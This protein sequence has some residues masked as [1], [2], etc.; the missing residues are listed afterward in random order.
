M[1]GAP[2]IKDVAQVAGVHFTTVS[3]ALRGHPSIRA[4][5][6]DR[7]VA[8]AAR[9]GYRKDQVFSALSTRRS[10][11]QVPLY[12]PKIAF[13]HNR[14]PENG[15]TRLPHFRRMEE[16]AR[17]QAEA[18]GYELETVFLDE[19]H[20]SSASLLDY[21]RA[22]EIRGIVLAVLEPGR[23]E[24]Q[25]PW[26]EFSVV[27]IETR[28]LAP[29]FL[30]VA[31]DQG[32]AVKTSLQRLQALGYQRIGL[33]IGRHDE[34]MTGDDNVSH[35]L[36]WSERCT[37]PGIPP[38]L[39]PENSSAKEVI[40]PLAA[41]V[42]EHRLDAVMCNWTNVRSMLATAGFTVPE[43]VAC[44]CLCLDRRTPGLAGVATALDLLAEHAVS[45]LATLLRTERRGPPSVATDTLVRGVW[46]AG[47][48]APLRLTA[49]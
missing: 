8:A 46:R 13:V 6:R 22:K 48:T 37:T 14:S 33:A 25:L 49:V 12:V 2:T 40:P 21:L 9:I 19:G 35:Y 42:R 47:A 1:P 44:A 5:T 27:R 32:Y 4:A 15:Y 23:R 39:F 17:A 16:A 45:L 36:Y 30:G 28:H 11:G 38:L 24:P 31:V 41:W 43:D 34:V 29:T 20:H 18:M 26:E 3:L 10:R 7:I